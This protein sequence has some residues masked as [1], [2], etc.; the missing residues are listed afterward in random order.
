[1]QHFYIIQSLI[2][3]T[4]RNSNINLT[5]VFFDGYNVYYVMILYINIKKIHLLEPP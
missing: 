5:F 2:W 1:M 4:T 3:K